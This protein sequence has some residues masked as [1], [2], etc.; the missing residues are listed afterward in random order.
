M[1]RAPAFCA[2][3]ASNAGRRAS[4][5]LSTGARKE[6]SSPAARLRVMNISLEA[7]K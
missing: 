4:S 5:A 6:Y 3:A 7:L 2:A 1:S